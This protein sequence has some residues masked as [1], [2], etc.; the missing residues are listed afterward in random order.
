MNE[1]T[2]V[3]LAGV[4]GQ[5]V[6]LASELLALAA[7]RVGH[8]TKQTEV[9]G[10]AQR[11]GSVHS[12]VRFG[13]TVY[14]PLIK[15]GEADVLIATE[16]LEALRFAH[17]VREGGVIVMN[18]YELPPIRQAQDRPI[19]QASRLRSG[20]AQ[21]RPIG[22]GGHY[23]HEATDFLR[24]KGFCVIAFNATERAAALGNPRVSNVMLLGAASPYLSISE[25]I[26]KATLEERLPTRLLEI[27]RR[28][29][30]E[31]RRVANDTKSGES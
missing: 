6:I 29:F 26:W 8:D 27:N 25:E 10:I 1:T 3:I 12:H 17:Y 2:N 13:G 23:P 18:S 28:A 24:S 15:P 4:G 19:R 20:Q 22:A 11:G 31:G 9:H 14:S 30:A 7:V 5:G 21:G 16:K